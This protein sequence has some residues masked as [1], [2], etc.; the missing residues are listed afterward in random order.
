[1]MNKIKID[2]DNIENGLIIIPQKTGIIY[3]NQVGGYN[4][5]QEEME[6]IIIPILIP[7]KIRERFINYM[8]YITEEDIR[9]FDNTIQNYN[10]DIDIK[11]NRKRKNKTMEAWLPINI[12]INNQIFNNCILT[13]ENSD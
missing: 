10:H 9:F 11:F 7:Q 4:C 6:G 13:W 8:N 5:E 12:K 2:L 3:K 1:M